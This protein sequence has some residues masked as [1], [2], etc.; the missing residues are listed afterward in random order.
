MVSTRGIYTLVISRGPLLPAHFW[1][2]VSTTTPREPLARKSDD[3]THHNGSLACI[4]HTLKLCLLTFFQHFNRYF[5][6]TKTRS[7]NAAQGCVPTKAAVLKEFL[8]SHAVTSNILRPLLVSPEYLLRD[9]DAF[10]S[11]DVFR[12]PHALHEPGHLDSSPLVFWKIAVLEGP[13]AGRGVDASAQMAGDIRV[14][15]RLHLGATNG[16]GYNKHMPTWGR[17]TGA[18]NMTRAATIA[19]ETTKLRKAANAAPLPNIPE[20]PERNR[21]DALQCPDPTFPTAKNIKNTPR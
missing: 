13:V 6:Q 4:T 15:W 17:D 21:A 16:H 5:V 1:R 14:A 7:T 9:V 11:E 10:S 20:K 19:P 12:P 18:S 3:T 2:I 8:S